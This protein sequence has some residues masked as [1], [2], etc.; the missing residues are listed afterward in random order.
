MAPSE[1]GVRR[2]S[3]PLLDAQAQRGGRPEPP[4]HRHHH[5]C[6]CAPPKTCAP[7]SRSVVLGP[8]KNSVRLLVRRL[9]FSHLSPF[10]PPSI[11]PLQSKAR[12]CASPS[13]CSTSGARSRSAKPSTSTT[14]VRGPPPGCCSRRKLLC[15]PLPERRH[16]V[17]AQRRALSL[18]IINRFL[19]SRRNP[20]GDPPG[21]AAG[22]RVRLPPRPD[23]QPSGVRRGP[24]P[25]PHSPVRSAS[26]PS[27]M[28]CM[29][30]E[31]PLAP[32]PALCGGRRAGL[33]CGDA[34]ISC[35]L[36][37][38][39]G[40]LSARRYGPL[41]WLQMGKAFLRDRPGAD[42]GQAAGPQGG[43]GGWGGGG[44]G[45]GGGGWGGGGGRG[46]R[47]G[48]NFGGGGGGR[49]GGGRGR[50]PAWMA[51][52]HG[53]RTVRIRTL[54]L[55]DLLAHPHLSPLG[56]HCAPRSS[57]LS[58]CSPPPQTVKPAE[59]RLNLVLNIAVGAYI[60]ARRHSLLT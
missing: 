60:R 7:P 58:V 12:T 49:G 17:A 21:G 39:R 3:D 56:T 9:D 40:E 6:C 28:R 4:H 30:I 31:R 50:G 22:P 14:A 46:G 18:T 57:L 42:G 25:G 15:C 5:R 23:A 37:L 2:S 20:A 52:H 38:S 41:R 48:G 45:G 47:G 44:G 11:S 33:T 43:P 55:R 27:K 34:G 8:N 36:C 13:L 16:P 1:L 32:L 51:V 53:Y 29:C 26:G 54:T 19:F 59:S 10:L 24:L 35:A